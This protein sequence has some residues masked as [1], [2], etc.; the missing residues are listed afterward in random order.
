MRHLRHTCV[1]LIV[2]LW[3]ASAAAQSESLERLVDR[4][5]LDPVTVAAGDL[6]PDGKWLAVTSGSLR[7]RIG[8]DN[9]RFGDPTYIAP[10]LVT[11][12]IVDTTNGAATKPF[13]DTRQVRGFKWSPDGSRLGFFMVKD[14]GFVPMLWERATGAV[15]AIPLPDGREAADNAEIEWSAD[16]REAFFAV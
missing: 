11:L 15:R 14:G 3:A 9:A 12:S 16:G 1:A 10:S 8:I 13:A 5:V 2:V 6:S 4:L 7:D